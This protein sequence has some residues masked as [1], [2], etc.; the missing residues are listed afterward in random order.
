MPA[1]PI[2][3]PQIINMLLS[4]MKPE[5]AVAYP[6]IPD[7]KANSIGTSSVWIAMDIINPKAIFNRASSITSDICSVMKNRIK[8][9]RSAAKIAKIA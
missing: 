1:L 7:M 2:R 3:A 4:I 6:L 5:A 9:R 8:R